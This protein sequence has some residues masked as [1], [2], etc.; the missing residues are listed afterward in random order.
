MMRTLLFRVSC[1]QGT[2]RPS[3][4]GDLNGDVSEDGHRA[5]P[6]ARRGAALEESAP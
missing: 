4:R 1:H 6:L 3:K 2:C 5:V